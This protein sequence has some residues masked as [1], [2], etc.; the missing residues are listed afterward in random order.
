M[1][2]L[3]KWLGKKE[4]AP[5]PVIT[6][7]FNGEFVGAH[8]SLD[9]KKV[10]TSLESS[11][12]SS[13]PTSVDTNDD[14]IKDTM[15]V[16]LPTKEYDGTQISDFFAFRSKEQPMQITVTRTPVVSAEKGSIHSIAGNNSHL[17]GHTAEKGPVHWGG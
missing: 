6:N 3:K 9:D 7:K 12:K 17:V 5:S 1:S 14:G 11:S 2:I 15:V 10:F 8:C 13:L 16:E 4:K